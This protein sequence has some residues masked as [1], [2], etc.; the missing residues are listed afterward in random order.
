M[1]IVRLA[2]SYIGVFRT[3]LEEMIQRGCFSDWWEAV[4][5]SFLGGDID[6]SCAD[7]GG[8]FWT[9]VDHAGDYARLTDWLARQP[10]RPRQEPGTDLVG[11]ALPAPA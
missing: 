6:V 4:L 7:V 3:R 5:Y 11:G 10:R 2:Q 8:A 1:G 9:E